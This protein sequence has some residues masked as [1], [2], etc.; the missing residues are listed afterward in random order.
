MVELIVSNEALDLYPNEVISLTMAINDLASIETRDGSYSNKFKLP[1][2]SNNNKILGYP[3]EINFVTGFKPTKSR[4]AKITIDGLDVQNGIIQIEQY[5]Q[6]DNSFSVSFFSGNTEWSDD[7]SDKDLQDIDLT[8]YNHLYLPS[9]VAASFSNTEGYIYPFINYGK[10]ETITTNQTSILDWSPAMYSH[11][12]VRELFSSAGWKVGGN[13]FNDP[14][15][16]KHI[17]PFSKRNLEQPSTNIQLLG[18]SYAAAN[19]TYA[20]ATPIVYPFKVTG[21]TGGNYNAATGVYTASQTFKAGIY[22]SFIR[23][24]V[25]P[26]DE[27]QVRRNGVV[28]HQQYGN[29]TTTILDIVTGDQITITLRL[30]GT[31][32]IPYLAQNQFLILPLSSSIEG[33]TMD[34]SSTLPDMKQ[35]DFIRTIFN[36]FGILFTTDSISKTVYLNTF[37]TI[38]SN[39]SNALDWTD[40]IDNSREIEV[41][42]TELVSD[43]GKV[44]HL[45]YT[46][47]EDYKVNVTTT[48]IKSKGGDGK[49]EIDNDFLSKNNELFESEFA[50]SQNT[51]CFNG[52]ATAMYIPRFTNPTIDYDA[53]DVDP[54]PRCAICVSDVPVSEV[55]NGAITT[56]DIVGA[57]GTTVVT[58]LPYPYFNVPITNILKVNAIDQSLSFGDNL[59]PNT[60]RTLVD[61]YY[62]DF[63]SILNNPRRV[64]VYLLLNERDINNLDYLTPIYLGGKLNSYFYINKISDYRPLTGGITKVE[65]ILI[66]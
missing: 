22:C 65:L 14:I 12:L 56:L 53:P 19:G 17:V 7:I 29:A 24:L 62:Q 36:Q 27:I 59:Q 1:S 11:T 41:D 46:P 44:N 42:Y 6:T 49:I 2:T 4:N 9:V 21:N 20:A 8:K 16:L 57:S 63:S 30:G 13:I 37:E 25:L 43:Y 5:N 3:S 15:F 33:S 34:M 10:Y 51:T 64:T 58:D 32:T 50:C 52:N 45:R 23:T 26:T 60:K 48:N 55:S 18:I 54:L 28:V 31:T 35:E 47:N 61:T 66:S 40:K 39:I 38:K